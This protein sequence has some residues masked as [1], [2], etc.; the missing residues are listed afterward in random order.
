MTNEQL[1]KLPVCV[2]THP[3]LLL[4]LE[5]ALDGHWLH[6]SFLT[7]LPIDALSTGDHAIALTLSR[8][9]STA[10]MVTDYALPSRGGVFT[11]TVHIV[12]HSPEPLPAVAVLLGIAHRRDLQEVAG[13]DV[14]IRQAVRSPDRFAVSFSGAGNIATSRLPC[15]A[16]KRHQLGRKTPSPF[17]FA[18][19]SSPSKP[20]A[21]PYFTLYSTCSALPSSLLCSSG[22]LPLR[23]SPC[24]RSRRTTASVTSRRRA[25]A[26]R[27]LRDRPSSTASRTG[28]TLSVSHSSPDSHRR[29]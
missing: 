17:D 14:S 16:H 22:P 4:K 27:S 9:W 21:P 24:R 28:R 12:Q 18:F 23:P 5:L 15:A 6:A 19:S 7:T 29:L 3:T 25:S 2:R 10:L 20:Y 8:V 26:R 1:T 13:V 11:A